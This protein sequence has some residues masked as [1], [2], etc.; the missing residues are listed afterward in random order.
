MAIRAALAITAGTEA[1]SGASK[2]H[3]TKGRGITIASR[4]VSCASWVN[5]ALDCCP[6]MSGPMPLQTIPCSMR[7]S[8]D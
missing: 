5:I 2:L 6:L 8:Q 7:V 4:I 3:L 1:G